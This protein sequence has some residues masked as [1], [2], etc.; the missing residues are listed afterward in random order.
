MR[1]DLFRTEISHTR[2]QYHLESLCN[3]EIIINVTVRSYDRAYGLV[4]R[5]Y[6]LIFF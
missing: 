3:Q 4:F 1:A 2:I 6:K 5:T